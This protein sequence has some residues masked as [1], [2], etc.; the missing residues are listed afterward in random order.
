MLFRHRCLLYFEHENGG[1]LN[2]SQWRFI[3]C[4][5]SQKVPIVSPLSLL[6]AGH[7]AA[8]SGGCADEAFQGNAEF[9]VQPPDHFQR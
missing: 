5:K 4:S 3:A 2:F 9:P 1:I 7:A 8:S 6:G